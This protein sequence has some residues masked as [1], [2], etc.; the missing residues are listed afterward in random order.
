ML[1]LIVC[2]LVFGAACML[3]GYIGEKFEN[4]EQKNSEENHKFP[5]K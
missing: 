3:V 5:N 1:K 2:V 4:R